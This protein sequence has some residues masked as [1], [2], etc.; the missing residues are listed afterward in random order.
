VAAA[1]NIADSLKESGFQ[2]NVQPLTFA[3]YAQRISSGNYDMYLGEVKLD[4]SM[5]ISQFF[6]E[7]TNF[8][9]GINKSEKVATEYFRY[10]AGEISA[11]EYYDIFTEYYPFVPVAFRSG[12]AVLSDDIKSLDLKNMPFSLYNGI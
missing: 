2:I 8:S 9:A 12:Y 11:K 5:D 7:G 4:G 3:D 6:K 10:R 1:Y